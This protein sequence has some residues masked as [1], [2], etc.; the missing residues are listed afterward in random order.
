MNKKYKNRKHCAL[1]IKEILLLSI[2]F[3]TNAQTLYPE[4]NNYSFAANQ[5][6]G[7][8][9]SD[10][11]I[12]YVANNSGLSRY[13][14][15]SWSLLE[16]P[17]K[18]I[19]RSVL[20]NQDL[21]YTGS[22]EEFGFWE[23]DEFGQLKYHSL[24][25]KF[26]DGDFI[27]SEEFWQIIKFNNKIL[28]RSFGSIY[29][30]D[31]NIIKRISAGFDIS[32]M[33]VYKGDLLIGSLSNGLYKLDGLELVS[34]DSLGIGE[35]INSVSHLASKNNS[36]FI[37][38][39]NTGAYLYK[40]GELN[41]L[42][43]KIN[44][45]LSKNII[46][47]VQ[48]IDDNTFAFGTI[49]NGVIIYDI[50]SD[51]FQIINK[52][53]GLKNNTVLGLSVDKNYLW[54][55]LDNGISRIGIKSEFGYYYDNT[56]QL[57]TVYDI[58]FFD[59]RYYLASNTGIFTFKNNQ[60]EL[61]GNSKGHSWQLFVNNNRLFCA[62]NNGT[63]VLEGD[64]LALVEGSFTGV[65]S[66]FS[67]DGTNDMLE[68][69]YSGVG[70]LKSKDNQLSVQR[71]E[72][73]D[74]PIDKIVSQND[75]VFWASHPY[76]GLYK[77]NFHTKKQ[78]IK[79]VFNYSEN[80][81][82][83]K[84]K[85]K[86]QKI[87]GTVYFVVNNKWHTFL[88]ESNS[89]KLVKSTGNHK[90]I[91]KH[92]KNIRF[93]D[94]VC[95][96]MFINAISNFNE[97]YQVTNNK[98]YSKSVKGFEKFVSVNDS[99][100]LINLIDGFAV[101]YQNK[102]QKSRLIEP[103]VDLITINGKLYSTYDDSFLKLNYEQAKSVKFNVY[104]PGS[105]ENNLMYHLKGETNEIESIID[106]SFKL[107]NLSDGDY[108]L[109][110]FEKGNPKKNKTINIEVLPIWYL[111][112]LMKVSYLLLLFTSF[113]LLKQY[114]KNK[115]QKA[116]VKKQEQLNE[117]TKQKILHI[118][119]NSLI[120]QIKIKKR[121]LSNTTASIIQKNETVILLINELNRLR[122]SSPD[123]E[124]TN[125]VIRT[126]KIQLNNQKDWQLFESHFKD[127]NEDFFKS[128]SDKF[129]RM[130]SKDLKL[131]AYIKTGL[132]SKEIAPLMGISAR[133]V[134]LHRYRLRKK[135]NFE[136]NISFNEFLRGF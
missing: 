64:R 136:V 9:V 55:A 134:E 30:Y 107:K 1:V 16:L 68:S 90:I 79:K 34:Y 91:S 22:Y 59:N 121:E 104:T 36:L 33:T 11:H 114:Q 130:T 131:C 117:E 26:E 111:S 24:N 48:F 108:V 97:K 105:F 52:E 37:N 56:G 28:F 80:P 6:W 82:F 60:L 129:P 40:D 115:I 31:G 78:R 23:K 84:K 54:V 63:Y 51:E 109:E 10:D 62:H 17:E 98:L 125:N 4:I 69:T 21:L 106:G 66:Y 43:K 57:G 14:G 101:L 126:A 39:L 2:S 94:T 20:Y 13:N 25:S 87:A 92:E 88:S 42:E 127:L 133:G 132:T 67:L 65:Y 61:I 128:L 123:L 73:L 41:F 71:L 102:I 38:D 81:I 49:K 76:K 32:C 58:V 113:Y 95:D 72:G 8:D 27:D 50:D 75:S 44:T 46:N 135:L 112:N 53:A 15:Q 5:N 3:I 35:K 122:K 83:Y 124:R 47:K 120:K 85:V 116:Q 96:S 77:L 103:V 89:F 7:I 110:I 74:F 119:K 19:I 70:L 86:L 12:V 45:F 99:T 118:E 29:I 18:M 100:K 93:T